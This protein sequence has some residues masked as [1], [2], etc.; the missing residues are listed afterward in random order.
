MCRIEAAGTRQPAP[1]TSH[2]THSARR[3]APP[4]PPTQQQQQHRPRPGA[5]AARPSLPAQAL[6]LH[7]L[8][9]CYR[10]RLSNRRR[11]TAPPCGWGAGRGCARTAPRSCRGSR[12]GAGRGPRCLRQPTA[13]SPRRQGRMRTPARPRPW[14]AAPSER[15]RQAHTPVPATTPTTPRVV[16]GRAPCRAAPPPTHPP[17]CVAQVLERHEVLLLAQPVQVATAEGERPEVFVD[18]GQQLLGAREPG[19]GSPRGAEGQRDRGSRQGG[20]G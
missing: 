6:E 7:A 11:G 19:R 5:R 20:G 1:P 16:P 8:L 10:P 17:T 13:S 9:P 4:P 14:P 15:P 3:C 18:G 2:S 12:T